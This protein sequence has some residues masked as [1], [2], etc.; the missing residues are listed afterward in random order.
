MIKFAV[1]GSGSKGNATFV[2]I[3]GRGILL[4]AGFT[5]KV[6]KS[7]LAS[8]NRSAG[9]IQMV[10]I[11]HQHGDH[12]Q[13]LPGLLKANSKIKVLTGPDCSG[14]VTPFLLSHDST[15]YGCIVKDESGNKLGYVTDTGF[16]PESA[17]PF[18]FDCSAIILEFNHD[19][20][21]LA[22]SPYP[23]SLQE[24]ISSCV[25]H[26]NNICSR[27]FLE[28]VA[29]KGLE[30]VVC[31]HLSSACNNRELVKYEAERGCDRKVLIAEQNEVSEMLV[32]I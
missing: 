22:D 25:G 21:L 3:D 5:W 17:Y 24:R 10:F 8:I 29:W 28:S 11:S 6:L 20:K 14:P 7:R 27:E 30:Y 16:I 18:L 9:D 13:A 31:F 15:C 32:L 19:L 26:M 23:V 4:D 2:E 1:L 12:V